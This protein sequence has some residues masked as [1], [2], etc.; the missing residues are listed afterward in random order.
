[1]NG[2]LNSLNDPV[3]NV[4]ILPL[5]SLLGFKGLKKDTV[6]FYYF[7]IPA[8]SLERTGFLILRTV[9]FVF[10]VLLIHCLMNILKEEGFCHV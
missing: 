4:L 10:I 7:R 1:V 6:E 9:S 5:W 3:L 8:I 2:R